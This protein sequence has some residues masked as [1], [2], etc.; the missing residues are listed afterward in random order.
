MLDRLRRP[1]S[2]LLQFALLLAPVVMTCFYFV[3]AVLGLV[4]DGASKLRWDE[5][6]REVGLGVLL[7]TL[8]YC[9]FCLLIVLL[10]R[11]GLHHPVTVSS[12]V[13]GIIAICLTALIFASS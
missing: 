8:G 4:I 11:G 10:K 13:H 6:A 7:L 9:S 12:L 1:I 5:E 2:P 3:Y